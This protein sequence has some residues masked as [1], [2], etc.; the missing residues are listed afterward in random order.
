M[1]QR[2]KQQKNKSNIAEQAKRRTIIDIVRE[3]GP[4]NIDPKAD[5][6]KLYYNEKDNKYG[7]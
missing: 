6:I 3:L 1:E 7:F 5:L 4:S 2:K